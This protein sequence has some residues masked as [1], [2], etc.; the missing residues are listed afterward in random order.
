MMLDVKATEGDARGC[1]R[2]CQKRAKLEYRVT[3]P[4]EG[5]RR[6]PP[7]PL[8]QLSPV[9]VLPVRALRSPTSLSLLLGTL[10]TRE[11]PLMSSPLATM[12]PQQQAPLLVLRSAMAGINSLGRAP[13]ELPISRR[14]TKQRRRSP[15]AT[16]ARM[17]SEVFWISGVFRA[18]VNW[19]C[20]S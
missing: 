10:S 3:A 2:R 6:T 19:C 13:K 11:I 20:E 4:L 17:W 8:I 14:S 12:F 1:S 18:C 15:L 9:R 5:L 16:R 7:P